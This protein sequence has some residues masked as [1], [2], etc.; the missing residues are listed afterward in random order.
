MSYQRRESTN[1]TKTGVWGVTDLSLDEASV[2]VTKPKGSALTRH[3]YALRSQSKGWLPNLAVVVG[4]TAGS[5]E[6]LS[7]QYIKV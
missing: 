7:S 6:R 3:G 2:W 1:N 4:T 5:E